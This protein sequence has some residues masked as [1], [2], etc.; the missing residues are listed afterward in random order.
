LAS[1]DDDAQDGLRIAFDNY[2][3]AGSLPGLLRS[4]GA[5][6]ESVTLAFGPERGWDAADRDE[7]RVSGFALVSLG[8]RVMRVETAIASAV[9]VLR[10]EL[11]WE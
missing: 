1:A 11:G 2:E 9:A 6:R 5:M 8:R 10:A 3:A 7:L 4:Q